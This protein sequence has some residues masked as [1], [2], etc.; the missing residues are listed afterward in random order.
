MSWY[1]VVF[2]VG[3]VIGIAGTAEFTSLWAKFKAKI[4]SE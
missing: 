3:L 1:A 4:K 2:L